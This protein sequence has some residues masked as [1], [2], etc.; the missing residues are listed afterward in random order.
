V[1][2]REATLYVPSNDL[3]ASFDKH[4]AEAESHPS[5]HPVSAQTMTLDEILDRHGIRTIDFLSIDIE[6]HEPQALKG[7]SIERFQP[8][9]V[10]VESHATGNRFSITLRIVVTS[11][12]A[13]I[14]ARTART[15]GSHPLGR[16]EAEA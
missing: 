14:C 2:D 11:S 5:V 8:R 7:F 15:C 3:I 13:S 9:L 10:G 12:S 1:S 6:L 4:F 16:L